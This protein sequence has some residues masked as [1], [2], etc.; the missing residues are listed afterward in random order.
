MDEKTA[1]AA[2]QGPCGVERELIV[3]TGVRTWRA[4]CHPEMAPWGSWGLMEQNEDG[5]REMQRAFLGWE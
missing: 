2:S 3:G 1:K 5:R 4:V